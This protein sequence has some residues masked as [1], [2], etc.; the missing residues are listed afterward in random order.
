MHALDGRG[1][2][3]FRK[4]A[5]QAAKLYSA[6]FEM[7]TSGIPLAFIFEDD[8]VVRH[9]LGCAYAALRAQHPRFVARTLL[10]SVVPRRSLIITVP[11]HAL[12][13]D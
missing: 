2:V 9:A 12:V 1:G 11:I 6:L 4:Y 3:V 8:V 7:V 10:S 5:S 13:S